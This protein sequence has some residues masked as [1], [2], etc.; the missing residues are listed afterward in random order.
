MATT[1]DFISFNERVIEDIPLE[2]I[3]NKLDLSIS[4]ASLTPDK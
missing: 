1:H 3:R 4:T 2:I